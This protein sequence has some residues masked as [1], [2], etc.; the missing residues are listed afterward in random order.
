MKNGDG[1]WDG[2]FPQV[3]LLV[4]PQAYMNSPTACMI[5]KGRERKGM[6]RCREQGSPAC[7]AQGENNLFCSLHSHHPGS[8]NPHSNGNP[9]HR[10]WWDIGIWGNWWQHQDRPQPSLL[11]LCPLTMFCHDPLGTGIDTPRS[12][13]VG[14]GADNR[15]DSTLP[16][17]LACSTAP[18][19][20]LCHPLAGAKPIPQ[21]LLMGLIRYERKGIK[22][23]LVHLQRGKSRTARYAKSGAPA[24]HLLAQQA[25]AWGGKV[26]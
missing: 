5:S 22:K 1:W 21:V 4:C 20:Q 10:Y 12:P 19:L 2:G 9:R 18:H 14:Y 6:C 16:H 8:T 15:T 17:P 24:L 7:Q 11:L 3:P 26:G 23:L 13:G 25:L